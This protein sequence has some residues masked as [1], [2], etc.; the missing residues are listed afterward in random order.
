[1]SSELDFKVS[2]KPLPQ[3]CS[4][5]GKILI[6]NNEGEGRRIGTHGSTS[7]SSCRRGV[8]RRKTEEMNE[9][10]GGYEQEKEEKKREAMKRK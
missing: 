2:L 4:Y 8:Q 9:E 3:Y 6:Q 7:A 5:Q 10:D 1:M